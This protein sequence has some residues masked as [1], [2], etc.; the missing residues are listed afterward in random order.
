MQTKF[1]ALLASAALIA[2]AQAGGH[3]GGGSGYAS[4][5]PAP[6]RGASGPSTVRSF[7][8]GRAIYS[9]QRFSSA[10]IRSPLRS[11]NPNVGT[12]MRARQ[13]TSPNVNRAN[14]TGRFSN[15]ENRAITTSR[16]GGIAGG[17]TRSGNSLPHNWRNHVVAQHSSNWHRD[18]DRR[19]D[20]TW[21]GH[22]CRFVNGSW[23]IFD[24]GFYPW[25]PYW[26]GPSDFYAYGYY[27]D[28]YQ[29]GTD[30]DDS[31][32]YQGEQYYGHDVN[33]SSD[34]YS[35]SDSTVVAAQ[36]RLARQGYYR[37]RVDGVL[38]PETR[39]A[40]A[41]YQNSHGLRATGD[42]SSDTLEALGLRRVASN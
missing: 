42:L 30:Y 2:Q 16:H 40:L 41:R 17:E 20:H 5:R 6:A 38:G 39:R 32:L 21:H 9:G 11:V 23:V 12:S 34:G 15:R 29:Y 13:F 26:Y 27:P 36:E 19:R 37:G 1:Y 35:E 24:L 31:N 3:H 33:E 8:T 10:G 14:R 18:W 4:A 22:H 7:G 28:S 25:W